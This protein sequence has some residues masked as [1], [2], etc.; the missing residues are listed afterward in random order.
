[1][2]IFMNNKIIYLYNLYIH[3]LHILHICTHSAILCKK[4]T[5]VN[6]IVRDSELC[7]MKSFLSTFYLCMYVHYTLAQY[8]CQ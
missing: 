3:L 4:K 7:N 8:I 1:M 5:I 2:N 6:D